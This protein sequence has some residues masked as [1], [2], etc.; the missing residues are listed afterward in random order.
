M[1]DYSTEQHTNELARL[2]NKSAGINGKDAVVLKFSLQSRRE[3]VLSFALRQD[4]LALPPTRWTALL[5]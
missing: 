1:L 5:D 2:G 3:R 4:N